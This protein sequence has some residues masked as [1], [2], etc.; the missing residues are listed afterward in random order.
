[1]PISIA[2]VDGGRTSVDESALDQFAASIR[3]ELLKPGDSKYSENPVYNAMAADRRPALI[4]R[5]TGTADVVDAVKFA[6]QHNLC[7]SRPRG[8]R[9]TAISVPAMERTM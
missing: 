4:V 2:T 1:M 8:A 3:G 6:R 5:C 7:S 9:P